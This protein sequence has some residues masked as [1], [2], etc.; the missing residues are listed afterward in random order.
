MQA[1]VSI[2]QLERLERVDACP[3][4]A[5]Q[6][7][8]FFLTS[9]DWLYGVPGDFP[10]VSCRAC[11]LV[12]LQ[13]RPR[14]ASL[15]LYYPDD[16][17]YAYKPPASHDLFARRQAAARLWY[18]IKRS[19]LAHNYG[20]RHLGGHSLIARLARLPLTGWLRERLT[21]HL[22]ILLHPYVENGHL[23][24]VGCGVGRYLDLM[25]ALGWQRTVGVDIS[26]T[27]IAQ[28]REVLGLEAYGG[29]LREVGL[30]ANSFD[31]VSLS[32]TLE[33]VPDPVTFLRD[34]F[35]VMKPGGRLAI[36]VPNIESLSARRFRDYWLALDTPRHL[37]N[38]TRRSLSIA[39]QEAGFTIER[40]TSLPRGGYQVAL[41][42]HSRAAG[43]A[44][45]IYSDAAHRYP[46]SRRGR[47]LM[48]SLIERMQCAVGLPAGEELA[49]VAV[50]RP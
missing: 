7:C 45:S 16:T 42:S 1:E 13:E 10:L 4:C 19:V 39:L 2:A 25:R 50:K 21:F 28:A 6:A 34:I 29:Q 38:F 20:Y 9:G 30:P 46:L 26:H 15:A 23:L 17:Y 37:I 41:F 11:G 31:A 49:A 35:Q 5:S 27:A 43:D 12:Y 24:E 22:D 18:F 14:A 36:I 32:H 47:A 8:S 48:L 3:V 40:M 44:H 33:H